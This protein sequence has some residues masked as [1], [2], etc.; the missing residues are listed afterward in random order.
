VAWSLVQ[1][2]AN[3]A[4]NAVATLPGNTTAGN[5]VVIVATQGSGTALTPPAGFSTVASIA[6]GTVSECYVMASFS[7]VG[8]QSS[9]T[10]T[11]GG[12][13][14]MQVTAAE[15]TCPNVAA[16]S[17]ASATG[18]NIAGATTAVTV[19]SGAGAQAGDLVIVAALQ[20]VTSA[21]TLTW[22][23]PAGFTQI[24]TLSVA[25]APNH[26][27]AARELSAPGGGAQV[28][29]V[30]S[31]LTG[32]ATGWTG[33]IASFSQPFAAAKSAPTVTAVDTSAASA[34]AGRTSAPTV[35]DPRDGTP[36]VS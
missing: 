16:A 8:G 9:W 28:A 13:G 21:N 11:G 30:T 18:T 14:A 34:A 24:G 6:N 19:T 1:Q 36:G 22:T 15:F 31:T 20:H 4:T 17:V 3:Q 27:Y 33:V 32:S 35:T 10:V 25:S 26:G 7:T 29:T 2:Q 12:G 5:L 23:D